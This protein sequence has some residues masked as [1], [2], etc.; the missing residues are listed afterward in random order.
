MVEEFDLLC[1]TLTFACISVETMIANVHAMHGASEDS[2]LTNYFALLLLAMHP[3]IQATAQK[4]LDEVV[5]R[6]RLP[7]I[8]DKPRLPYTEA[9]LNEIIRYA[10]S[11]PVTPIHMTTGI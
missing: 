11:V 3:D 7:S 6:A 8:T 4:E 1:F 5:G 9:V 10:C 2:F